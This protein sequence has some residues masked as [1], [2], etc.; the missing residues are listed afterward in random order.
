[1]MRAGQI[2]ARDRKT[3]P[4][5]SRKMRHPA[6]LSQRLRGH[7]LAGRKGQAWI[8]QKK[9]SK[10]EDRASSGR[11]AEDR[12]IRLL[13]EINSAG[14]S[15]VKAS[16][17]DLQ[18]CAVLAMQVE[19]ALEVLFESAAKANLDVTELGKLIRDTIVTRRASSHELRRS[20]GTTTTRGQ[21]SYA[22][23]HIQG[24][25]GQL[26]D[27]MGEVGAGAFG[28]VRKAT[29]LKT[30]EEHAV[31]C[32]PKAKV[33]STN[34]WEEI[35]IM[36][37]LDHPHIMRVYNTFED[38]QYI[39]MCLELCTGG[40]FF[41]TLFRLGVVP[42]STAATLFKQIMNVISYIHS[43][44]ICHRDIKPENFLVLKKGDIREAHLKLIDFGCSKRFDQSLMT[45]KICTPQYVAPEIL[46]KGQVSYTEKVDVWSCGV[47]LYLML[48]GRLPFHRENE[49][50][51]LKLVKKGVWDFKPDSLWSIV[52]DNAKEL[53]RWCLCPV[54]KRCT[55]AQALRS[56]WLFKDS[57]WVRRLSVTAVNQVQKYL[58]E[59][60]LKRVALRIIA[61]QINDE[62]IAQL[63]NMFLQLDED[64]TG[65]LSADEI[66]EAVGQMGVS[67][68]KQTGMV[69]LMLHLD[70]TGSGMIEYTEFL[71]ATMTPQQYCQ[72]DVCRAAFHRLDNDLD[73]LLT[74]KDLEKLLSD[75]DGRRDAGLAE[76]TL[77]EIFSEMDQM[78]KQA[79]ED[80]SGG[81]SF[82]E[83]MNFMS[84]EGQLPGDSA[85]VKRKQRGRDYSLKQFMDEISDG[86]E[87]LNGDDSE[88][89]ADA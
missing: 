4:I 2:N 41:D 59:S 24:S 85:C 77:G 73:G 45:T 42:E 25:P 55:A 26:Y 70:P 83:F 27:L 3:R 13:G 57:S 39:Y 21:T 30:G 54:D 36:K 79:D 74:R 64:C 16:D 63:R 15:A 17:E 89:D 51:M 40:P 37:L 48:S 7:L 5:E 38:D 11:I 44:S 18:H 86:E 82:E 23:K 12:W 61:R 32:V 71:A 62:S 49:I 76:A 67:K 10:G 43:R 65:T 88:D 50:E 87:E 53:V 19:D 35:E 66:Q 56:D 8:N 75:A 22:Y 47:M 28:T 20:I 33:D 9:R 80:A 31:K 68:M 58:S 69:E 60:R 78:M 46:L 34:L 84:E 72:E 52:S 1:V 14:S 6:W 81:V 29:H